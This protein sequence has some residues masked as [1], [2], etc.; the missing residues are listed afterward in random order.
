MKFKIALVVIVALAG[1]YFTGCTYMIECLKGDGNIKTVDKNIGNFNKI[2]LKGTGNIHYSSSDNPSLRI[3]GDANIIEHLLTYVK[4]STLI[5]D[6][7]NPICPRKLDFYVSSKT[8]E[9]VMIKGAGDVIG[10]DSIVTDRFAALIEGSGDIKLI[11]AAKDVKAEI[12][13]S[14]NI[15]L[16]GYADNASCVIKG[17]GDIDLSGAPSRTAKVGIY[18][19]GN[20]MLYAGESLRAEIYGSGDVIYYGD[21]KNF[22]SKVN[23]SGEV[24][25]AK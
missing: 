10:M 13:G 8:L 1:I 12:D 25:K 11:I 4:G 17:S 20:C 9:G 2:L 21:P 15:S 14:G 3:E 22:V 24:R 5:I 6:A 18:G 19:S 7:D 23:G 16:K